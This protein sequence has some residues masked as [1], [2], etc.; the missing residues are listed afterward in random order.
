LTKFFTDCAIEKTCQY[1]AYSTRYDGLALGHWVNL[2]APATAATVSNPT[3][4]VVAAGA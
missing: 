2:A 1:D 3:A 4:N